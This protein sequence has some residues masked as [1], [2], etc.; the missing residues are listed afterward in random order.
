MAELEGDRAAEIEIETHIDPAG[1]CI[2]TLAGE[3]DTSNVASLEATMASITQQP[4]LRLIFDLGDLRFMDSAG[5]AV[6]LKAASTSSSVQL[7]DPS[8]IVQRVLEVTGLTGVLP[9]E[10]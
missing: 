8:P 10:S 4:P 2:V 9:T 1:T 5:I 7:R 3:L 6:L